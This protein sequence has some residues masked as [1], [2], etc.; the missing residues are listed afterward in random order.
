MTFSNE[1]Q[2]T[3][4]DIALLQEKLEK[5]EELE[6]FNSFTLAERAYKK[7]YGHK[8]YPC[9]KWDIFEPAYN[10]GYN[11]GMENNKNFEPTPQEQENNEWRNVALRFGEELVS[12]GPCGYYDMTANDWLEWA[13]D[14]YGKNCDGWLKLVL[15]KQRKYE[16]LTK[17]LQEKTVIEPTPQTPEQ[18]EQGLRDAMKK[19]KEDGVFEKPKPKTLYDVIYE[20]KYDTYDPTCDDL[21]NMIEQWL[22]DEFDPNGSVYEYEI[23]WNEAIQ[24]I[25]DKLK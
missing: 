25:K 1:I 17:K 12:I 14:A 22:P 18:V 3:K 7:R 20:W 10:V 16:A 23:G 19:A 21:V 2:Q 9:G 4:E 11:D 24:S 6:E 8:P 15:K 5:L 13:K